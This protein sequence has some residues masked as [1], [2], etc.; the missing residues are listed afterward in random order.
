M[1]R[2]DS[3]PTARH[4]DNKL[5][6]LLSSLDSRVVPGLLPALGQEQGNVG[7]LLDAEGDSRVIPL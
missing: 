4:H 2:L 5:H 3:R 6:G 7:V 1:N